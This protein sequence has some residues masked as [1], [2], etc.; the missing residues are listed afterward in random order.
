MNDSKEVYFFRITIDTDFEGRNKEKPFREI[1]LLRSQSLSTL[2]RAI[3]ASV[4]FDF[5]HCYGFYDNFKDP[6]ESK[7]IY[8]LFTDIGEDS[9]SG[10][11]GVEHIPV[12]RAFPYISKKLRFLFDYGDNW[13]FTV[14]LCDIKPLSKRSK[15]PKVIGINGKAP[16]QHP[17]LEDENE[18]EGCDQHSWFHK[19]C[20]VCRK[21][22]KEGDELRWFPDEPTKKK[23]TI[24]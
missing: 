21:L 8:E 10:A 20:T 4:N 17:S 16:G 2:A 9:T 1:A 23:R 24:H 18:S 15:Y 12:V 7:E 19:D 22:E 6:F 13:Q 3:V 14:E 11:L 5:D